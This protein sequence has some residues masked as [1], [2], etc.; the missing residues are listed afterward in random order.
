MDDQRRDVQVERKPRKK[1][2]GRKR[3]ALK[4]VKKRKTFEQIKEKRAGFCFYA[5]IISNE[6][7]IHREEDV[8]SFLSGLSASE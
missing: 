6:L 1:E 2:K 3:Q 4:A 7:M 8:T 5:A